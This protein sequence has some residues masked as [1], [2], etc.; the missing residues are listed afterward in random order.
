[1]DNKTYLNISYFVVIVICLGAAWVAYLWLR[2]PVEG[3][4]NA[5]P[6][7]NLGSFIKRAFPL[8]ILLFVLSA[9]LSVSY[10]GG[11]NPTPYD[12]IVADRAYIIS[13]NEE[14]ISASLHAVAIGALLWTGIIAFSLFTV[15]PGSPRREV[16]EKKD[17]SGVV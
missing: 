1:M 4:A 17:G 14:Q 11:C 3:I 8:S 2:R 5:L 10:P 9:C 6:R 7:Q 12:K 15:Q 13:K 16:N